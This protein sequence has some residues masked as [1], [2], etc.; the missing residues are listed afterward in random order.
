MATRESSKVT[1]RSDLGFAD[2]V[3]RGPLRGK[4]LVIAGAPG[5]T[6][7]AILASRAA[8]AIWPLFTNRVSP[9]ITPTGQAIS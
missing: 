9:A 6:G 7:A 8:L 3:V 1:M 4:V 5:Y 2:L